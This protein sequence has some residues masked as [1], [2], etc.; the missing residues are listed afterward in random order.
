MQQIVGEKCGLDPKGEDMTSAIGLLAAFLTVPFWGDLGLKPL[1]PD[2]TVEQSIRERFSADNALRTLLT[3]EEM[4]DSLSVAVVARHDSECGE[5]MAAIEARFGDG[6]LVGIAN[7]PTILEGAIRLQRLT[8]V[9]LEYQLATN[10]AARGEGFEEVVRS[11]LDELENAR[12][13]FIEFWEDARL[14]D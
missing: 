4:L 8:I 2:E 10:K 9:E 14:A 13:E 12:A 6:I 11:A 3:V 7:Y 1:H 5:R